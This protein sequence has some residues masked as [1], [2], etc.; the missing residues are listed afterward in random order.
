MADG[1]L[2]THGKQQDYGEEFLHSWHPILFAMIASDTHVH[3]LRRHMRALCIDITSI[4]T[5]AAFSSY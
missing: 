2:I 1:N 4:K 5:S 3:D